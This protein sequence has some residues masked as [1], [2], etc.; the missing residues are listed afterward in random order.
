M[1]LKISIFCA[2]TIEVRG[3]IIIE[4]SDDLN[5]FLIKL[6]NFTIDLI[7]SFFFLETLLIFFQLSLP[8]PQVLE[9]LKW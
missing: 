4:I 5:A 3:D 1:S 2:Q 7:C 9:S 8:Q 6:A